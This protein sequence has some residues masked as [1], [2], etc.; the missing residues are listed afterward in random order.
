MSDQHPLPADGAPARRGPGGLVGQTLKRAWKG[1]IFSE[2]AEAAFWQ[3]LSLPPLLLGLLGSL[4]YVSGWFGQRVLDEVQARIISFSYT[5]FSGNVVEDIVKPTV[6]DILLTGRGEVVSI[7]FLLSLWAGSSA[8]SSFVDA[9]T[10]AHDQYTVRNPVWQR[11]FALLLYMASLIGLIIGLPLLALGPDI[12]PNFFPAS[13]REQVSFYVNLLYYPAL[14][15]LALLAVTTLY[16]LA[17]PRKLPWHRGVPGAVLAVAVFMLASSLLRLYISWITTTGYTY[18]ALATPIALLLFTFFIGFAIV[19]G[20]HFNAAIQELWPAKMTRRQRRRWRR[21]EMERV[22]EHI[23]SDSSG[24]TGAPGAGV[25]G[26]DTVQLGGSQED[27]GGSVQKPGQEPPKRAG[28]S[29]SR[30]TRTHP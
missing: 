21:L 2:A 6:Q 29:S 27:P 4:G 23:R 18:G 17:L 16:K 22:A 30:P 7:G 28:G 13:W 5:I 15:I 25:D 1:S 8:M 3:T 19:L 12:L 9:I 11:I 10:S 26:H 20:A 14:G 24:G